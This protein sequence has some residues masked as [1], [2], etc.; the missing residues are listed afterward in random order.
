MTELGNRYHL[1][2]GR[3][4]PEMLTPDEFLRQKRLAYECVTDDTKSLDNLS[5]YWQTE[6]LLHRNI[7]ILAGAV[8]GLLEKTSEI[9]VH[10][11]RTTS[12]MPE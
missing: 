8:D 12:V 10:L 5:I 11:L 3:K 2:Q 9:K 6:V 7:G 4:E 1:L